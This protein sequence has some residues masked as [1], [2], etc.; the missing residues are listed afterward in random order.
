MLSGSLRSAGEVRLP[1]VLLGLGLGLANPAAQAASL[2]RVARDRS[3]MAAGVGST[4]RYLGGVLGV[5]VLA[6]VLDVSGSRASVVAQHHL[7][8]GIFVVV[9]L[10]GLACVSLLPGRTA[11]AS[12]VP[13]R[14]RRSAAPV[15]GDRPSG[16]SSLRG[17]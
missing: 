11:A 8:L 5:A 6:R 10:G 12:G 16:G 13:Q 7:L 15:A 2:A 9:L 4:M 1:L 14:A 3:G 17:G